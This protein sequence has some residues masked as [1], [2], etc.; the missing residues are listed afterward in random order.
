MPFP[1]MNRGIS[2]I[3]DST[4]EGELSNFRPAGNDTYPVI[5]A[6]VMQLMRGMTLGPAEN[7]QGSEVRISFSFYELSSRR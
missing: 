5:S 4:P 1:L 3:A 7:G 6:C 2:I